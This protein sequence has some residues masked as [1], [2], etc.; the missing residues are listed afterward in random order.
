MFEQD[1]FHHIQRILR[2]RRLERPLTQQGT[3]SAPHVLQRD[4]QVPGH[5]QRRP[6]EAAR[7]AQ[8]EGHRY[9]RPALFEFD[10]RS[11]AGRPGQHRARHR[12]H[13]AGAAERGE[14]AERIAVQVDPHAGPGSGQDLLD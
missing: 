13:L 1:A 4:L 6:E 7:R 2:R 9:V 10:D 8:R 5:V 12:H 11:A 3:R 14:R